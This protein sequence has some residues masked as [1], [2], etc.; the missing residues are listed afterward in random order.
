[1]SRKITIENGKVIGFESGKS[2]TDAE[3]IVD[4][5]RATVMVAMS[6]GISKRKLLKMIK[7]SWG[8]IW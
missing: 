7:S 8:R 3:R 5:V 4:L 1:M 2:Y 6:S